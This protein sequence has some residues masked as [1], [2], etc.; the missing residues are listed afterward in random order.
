MQHIG[1]EYGRR[2]LFVQNPSSKR[3]ST[4]HKYPLYIIADFIH[5]VKCK[6]EIFKEKRN[7]SPKPLTTI[8]NY[9]IIKLIYVVVDVPTCIPYRNGNERIVNRSMAELFSKLS[10]GMKW[11]DK[12]DNFT[13]DQIYEAIEGTN[14]HF[15]KPWCARTRVQDKIKIIKD[16]DLIIIGPNR[17]RAYIMIQQSGKGKV[18][19][20]YQDAGD[21]GMISFAPDGETLEAYAQECDVIQGDMMGYASNH[22]IVTVDDMHKA[23]VGLRDTGIFQYTSTFTENTQYFFIDQE[24]SRNAFTLYDKDNQSQIAI[25][26]KEGLIG[27]SFEFEPQIGGQGKISM[28]KKL[29]GILPSYELTRNGKSY[30]KIKQKVGLT[31]VFELKSNDG[32]FEMAYAETSLSD[33]NQFTVK[34]N[35]EYIATIS[36][37]RGCSFMCY[38]YNAERHYL[39]YTN[40]PDLN[41]VISA[42]AC[43][44][45]EYAEKKAWDEQ[46]PSDTD[47]DW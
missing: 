45:M 23:L 35:G 12:M 47:S 6:Q 28:K 19:V 25:K 36:D 13:L 3:I 22:A 31:S 15:G 29:I 10:P 4:V 46:H 21:F 9:G 20:S 5:F 38:D 16:I 7:I 2:N 42:F 40:R 1:T 17:S 30:G 34:L 27:L 11:V 33:G 44:G 32:T 43:V 37:R 39:I 8:V 24:N 41:D 18:M 26:R 14:T